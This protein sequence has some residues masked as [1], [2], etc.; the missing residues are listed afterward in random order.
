MRHGVLEGL[1]RGLLV[2]PRLLALTGH[3]FPLR[4]RP[5]LA[6]AHANV[7]VHAAAH[8]QKVVIVSLFQSYERLV[9]RLEG[10]LGI[11]QARPLVRVGDHVELHPAHVLAVD[12][13]V[14]VAVE[15]EVVHAHAV[16]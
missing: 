14:H 8:V 10:E 6:R 12:R 16:F 11:G 7:L 3:D 1:A 2:F 5:L 13:V 9:R 4:S 15:R